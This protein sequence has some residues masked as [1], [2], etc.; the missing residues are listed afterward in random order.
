MTNTSTLRELF[1]RYLSLDLPLSKLRAIVGSELAYERDGDEYRLRLAPELAAPVVVTA[2][3]VRR[4]LSAAVDKRITLDELESWANLLILYDGF[5]L[6]NST[7]S[8][9]MAVLHEI[10]SP[11]IYGS[12]EESRLRR[13]QA[14]IPLESPV[15]ET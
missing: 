10:A 12:L 2:T 13:L 11:S 14:R 7:E 9:L 5:E 6:D 1:E 15:R 8:E 4:A 3:H